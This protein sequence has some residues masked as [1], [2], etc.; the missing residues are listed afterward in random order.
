MTLVT[1][2]SSARLPASRK[3]DRETIDSELRPVAVLCRAARER[4]GSLPSIDLADALLDERREL[5]DG[6]SAISLMSMLVTPHA[7]TLLLTK[8]DNVT[9]T[10]SRSSSRAGWRAAA[11]IAKAPRILQVVRRSL[12]AATARTLP[13]PTGR[14]ATARPRVPLKTRGATNEEST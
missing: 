5:A 2:V 7:P 9:K 6:A 13:S 10:S 14:I 11:R 4:G 1:C 8:S 3:R 12:S